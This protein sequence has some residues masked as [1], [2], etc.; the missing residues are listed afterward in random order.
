MLVAASDGG[1]ALLEEAQRLSAVFF[2]RGISVL[3]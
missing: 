2:G 1:L 3:G